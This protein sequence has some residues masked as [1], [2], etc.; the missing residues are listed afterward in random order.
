MAKQ[1]KSYTPQS[2]PGPSASY[3]WDKWLDGNIWRLTQGVDFQCSLP[4]IT[5]LI[6]KTAKARGVAV[7]IYKEA[8][9]VVITPPEASTTARKGKGVQRPKRKSK[10]S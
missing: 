9:G 10:S 4:S 8:D 7:S 1:L 6:R 5:D 2:K 3:P